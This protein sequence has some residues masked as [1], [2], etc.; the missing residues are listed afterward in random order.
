MLVTGGAGFMGSSFANYIMKRDDVCIVVL[1]DLTYASDL[2]RLDWTG[3]ITF[4][5]G[6]ISDED[7]VERLFREN[8]F[9]YVVNFAAETHVD[10][11]IMDS[12]KFL[13]SNV[14]G[15]GVLLDAVRRHGV[16]R[17]H[18]ISTDEV[19]GDTDFSSE[20]SFDEMSPLRPSNPYSASK[21]AA[22]MLCLS[23]YRTYGIPVTISRSVNNYGSKQNSEKFIPKAIEC[24]KSGRA[25]PVYGSGENIRSWIHTSDHSRA[26]DLILRKG[27]VGEVYNISAGF[28]IRNIDVVRKL[29]EILGADES[30]I[31]YVEDR[32]G[33]DR[34]YSLDC[35]KISK[36]G[37]SA[38]I[39]FDEGLRALALS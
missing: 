33:H 1:D 20:E 12:R 7:L 29:L 11:S 38:M 19:Y 22:D 25:V 31:E 9:D 15:V 30:L 10:R 8:A 23:Y 36:L 26:V 4:V 18:Q 24:I 5:K 37:F 2:S 32:P 35:S 34:R 17:L 27:K 21:A 16:R 6:D 14:I 39:S 3:K 13:K 28:E